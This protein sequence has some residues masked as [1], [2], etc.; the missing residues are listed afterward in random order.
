MKERGDHVTKMGQSQEPESC[1]LYLFS[2]KTT[3]LCR[4]YVTGKIQLPFP[5]SIGVLLWDDVGISQSQLKSWVA[6]FIHNSIAS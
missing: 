6:L 1:N 2:Y 3:S 5:R 4:L